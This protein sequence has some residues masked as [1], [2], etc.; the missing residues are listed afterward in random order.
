MSNTITCNIASESIPAGTTNAEQARLALEH[1]CS[2]SGRAPA[3]RY[4]SPKFVDYVN[5]MTFHG[6]EGA[7]QSVSMYK[8]VL[9]NIRISVQEQVVEGDKVTSRFVVRGENRGRQVSF[10]GI[11]ISRLENGLIVEDW[12]VTDT[13]GMLRQLGLWRTTLV[14]IRQWKALRSASGPGHATPSLTPSA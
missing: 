14:G 3:S 7:Q 4:Y 1:V 9:S 11:T 5:D 8:G 12:S 2:G 10:N 6:L 13:L